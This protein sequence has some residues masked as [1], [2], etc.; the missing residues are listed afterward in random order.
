MVTTYMIELKR[1]NFMSPKRKIT[2]TVSRA[3]RALH[4]L[5]S[6]KFEIVLMEFFCSYL[7]CDNTCEN[8]SFHDDIEQQEFSP[9]NL[10]SRIKELFCLL[11]GA[12]INYISETSYCNQTQWLKV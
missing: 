8:S 3:G 7:L 9:T 2:R 6:W 12:T 11:M 10:L 1:I 5:V 4:E